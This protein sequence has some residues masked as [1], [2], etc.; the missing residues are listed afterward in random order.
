MAESG[1]GEAAAAPAR[2]GRKGLDPWLRFALV[3]GAL[4]L[5]SEILY[6]AVVLGSPGL[7]LYLNGLAAVS[8]RIVLA[9]DPDAVTYGSQIGSGFFVVDIAPEC[10]A[11]Q[12]CA[13]L[14]AAI[15]AFPAPLRSRLL[16]IAVS[17]ALLQALN[18]ARIVSLYYIGGIHPRHFDDA[19]KVWW[20]TI[21]IAFT[22]S[23]WIAW[24]RISTR[25]GGDGSGPAA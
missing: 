15:V 23:L 11:I 2:A 6:F 7:Q 3:F 25:H 4:A 10:D 8:H 12:L 24:A 20:P 13:M 1:E 14:A 22:V 19:H 9:F 18:F 17:L 5:L 21:L 16:G